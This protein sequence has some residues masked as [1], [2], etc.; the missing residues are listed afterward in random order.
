MTMR[1]ELHTYIDDMP[2]YKLIALQ[3]LLRVMVDDRLIIETDLTDSEYSDIESEL[4][5]YAENPSIGVR[6]ENVSS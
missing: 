2:E 4:K 6:L 1:Q 3:P 5:A